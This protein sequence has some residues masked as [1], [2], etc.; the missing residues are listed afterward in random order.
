MALLLTVKSCYEED[1][2]ITFEIWVFESIT[3]FYSTINKAVSSQELL[4]HQQFVNLILEAASTA[5]I[6]NSTDVNFFK[7]YY[8]Y[9]VKLQTV[10][11]DWTQQIYD[12]YPS[13]LEQMKPSFL[14]FLLT[15]ASNSANVTILEWAINE[16][17]RLY[18]G[19]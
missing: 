15:I 16:Y 3:N 13:C 14:M 1:E 5:S 10:E 2:Y 12:L 17:D 18:G 9:R 8:D 11:G 6:I 19:S 4:D 7:T